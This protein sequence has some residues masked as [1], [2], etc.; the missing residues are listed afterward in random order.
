MGFSPQCGS[1]IDRLTSF[2]SLLKLRISLKLFILL[3]DIF[4]ISRL[5]N[6]SRDVPI[7]EILLEAKFKSLSLGKFRRLVIWV[8]LFSGSQSISKLVSFS[9]PSILVIL[10]LLKFRVLRD[11]FLRNPLILVMLFSFSHSSSNNS[12]F[13]IPY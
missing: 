5:F 10:L 8:M 12:R 13:S 11:L 7:I 6:E 9:S 3:L 4:K 1:D 2:G